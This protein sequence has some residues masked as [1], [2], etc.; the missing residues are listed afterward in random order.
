MKPIY[1]IGFVISISLTI[2]ALV[3][4]ALY[5]LRFGADFRGGSVL[6]LSF[7]SRPEQLSDI[8]QVLTTIPEAHNV[9]VS[10]LGDK[11]VLIRLDPLSEADH[12]KILSTL[13][14][15]FGTISELRFNSIGPTIGNELKQ[16]SLTAISVLL[17][18]IVIYIAFVFRKLSIVISPWA[19]GIATIM[20]LIH[21]LAI[22]IAVFSIL[23]RYYGI[24]ISAVF[25]A[26]ALTILGY[27]VSDSVVVLDRMRENILRF[28]RKESFPNLVHM[29]IMQTLTRS[30]NT[31][32]NTLLSLFAV[33]FFGGE[34]IRYFAL[35]LI[36]GI[37]LGAYSSI[38]VASPILVWWKGQRS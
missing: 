21:D 7:Q 16:K 8:T 24:E 38:F 31:T 3:V 15:K 19:M 26:A 10:P 37:A 22:P 36:I 4:I 2:A 34:S 30:L 18:A 6:E 33:Y 29:S 1:T 13:S 35:A 17:I 25:V 20:A 9:S 23:G 14:Q 28:G 11:N 27:S 12:Q 32:F 5:G